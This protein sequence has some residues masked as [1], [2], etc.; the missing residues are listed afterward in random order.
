[1]PLKVAAQSPHF[2]LAPLQQAPTTSVES[3]PLERSPGWGPNSLWAPPWHPCSPAPSTCFLGI[4]WCWHRLVFIM[5]LV[6]PTASSR[7]SAIPLH[8]HDSSLTPLAPRKSTPPSLEAQIPLGASHCLWLPGQVLEPCEL[9]FIQV[10]WI[11]FSR[12]CFL[13]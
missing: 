8:G 6:T 3:W 7:T 5:K 13:T 2:H 10:N 1:M 11:Q 12:K 4:S 9:V